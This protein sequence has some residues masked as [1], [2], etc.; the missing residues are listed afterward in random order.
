MTFR[1]RPRRRCRI[2]PSMRSYGSVT[3]LIIPPPSP[4]RAISPIKILKTANTNVETVQKQ[5][6]ESKSSVNVDLCERLSSG[7][8]LGLSTGRD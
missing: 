3:P 7:E 1:N 5:I 6:E 2:A 8:V 4:F